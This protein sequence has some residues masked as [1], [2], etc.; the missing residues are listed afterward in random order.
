MESFGKLNNRFVRS[1]FRRSNHKL[2]S[3]VYDRIEKNTYTQNKDEYIANRNG[4]NTFGY[5]IVRSYV[6]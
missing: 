5:V 2:K 6:M 3:V 4:F 1:A